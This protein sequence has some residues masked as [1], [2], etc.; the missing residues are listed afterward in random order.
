MTLHIPNQSEEIMLDLIL[1][2]NT[3]LKLHTNDVTAGLTETQLNAL[4][5]ASF[6]E[7]TFT[8]Y[9]AKTLTGGS[10]V[11]T[12]ATPSTGTYAQQTFT[13]TSTGAA[14]VIYGYHVTRSSDGKL[15]WHERFPGPIST[16]T[17]GD[18]IQIT[19]TLTLD[20]NQ[21]ADVAAQ[22]L[23]VIQSQTAASAA[24]TA[25]ATTDFSL[26]NFD[27]DGTRNYRVNLSTS[28]YVT[29]TGVWTAYLQIDGTSVARMGHITTNSDDYVSTSWVWQPVTGQ[30]DLTIWLNEESGT[31][32]LNFFAAAT[33]SR[34][35]WIEDIGPR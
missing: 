20:D 8:G 34:E 15:L 13:R 12:Q 17:N 23:K 7:A 27:A 25:N 4:T 19:P 16:S 30:Y 26:A 2:A 29:G 22:G 11:T 6:T 21:E 10:W 18:T 28:W 1:A 3:Q 14:Q 24:Y 31:S 33:M 35:F 32:S 5:E 9:A